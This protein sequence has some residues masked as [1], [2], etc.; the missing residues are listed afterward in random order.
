MSAPSDRTYTA[1][2][3][4]GPGPVTMPRELDPRRLVRRA[5]QIVLALAAIALIVILAPGLGTLMAIGIVGPHRSLALTAAPAAAAAIVIVAVL[6]VPRFGP[7]MGAA[8][9]AGRVTRALASVRGAL[10]GGTAEA[11]RILRSGD[12]QVIA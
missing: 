5:V 6:L 4:S 2:P 11:V 12:W 10:V 3:L 1:R 9:D 8:P 7:G